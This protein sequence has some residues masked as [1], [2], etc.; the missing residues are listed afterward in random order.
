MFQGIADAICNAAGITVAKVEETPRKTKTPLK[1]KFQ[2][3]IDQS[4]FGPEMPVKVEKKE[5][6]IPVKK[7]KKQLKMEISTEGWNMFDDEAPS[8]PKTLISTVDTP[9]SD[10]PLAKKELRKDKRTPDNLIQKERGGGNGT[11]V[12]EYTRDRIVGNGAS[13]K[14]VVRWFSSRC[15]EKEDTRTCNQNGI[16][17]QRYVVW[18]VRAVT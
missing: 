14:H 11:E 1:E 18:G 12:F 7:M 2:F 9:P 3:S 5:T 4:C 10:T 17:P 15:R 8:T 13:I 6:P 16:C